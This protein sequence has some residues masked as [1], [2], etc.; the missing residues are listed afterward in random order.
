MFVFAAFVAGHGRARSSGAACARGGR[1][2]ASRC[3]VALV[4]ARAP[5]PAPLRRLH[6]APRRRACC[7]SASP[8]RRPSS[9]PATCGCAP[10]PDRAR[11]RLRHHLR[12][13]TSARRRGAERPA[14]ADRPRRAAARRARTASAS[15]RCAPTRSYFPSA[16]ADARPRG[17]L[18]RGRGDERGRRCA[19]GCARDIWTAVSPDLD[20]LHARIKRGRQASSPAPAEAAAEQRT[21]RS[22]AQALTGLA[23]L[24]RDDPPPATFRLIV[25]PLVTWIWLGAL[26]VFGGG[27]DRDLA[28]ARRSRAARH[29]RLRGARRARARPRLS[30][31]GWTCSE[32]LLVLVVLAPWSAW[33]SARRCAAGARRGR[34]E[35]E[36]AERAELEAAQGGQVPR[37]PRRR[38][39]LPDGK[40]SEAD[41]RAID[42]ALRAEAIEILRELDELDDSNS[43][44]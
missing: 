30:S 22:S 31:R 13:P 11:R 23:E 26:I 21:T 32:S 7:S 25:S 18:L 19:P 12:K 37:D 15:R 5:Q 43:P 1:W 27:A 24:L 40:L 20:A 41:W 4:V 3:R 16:D 44:T 9:T 2:P 6:R 8:P 10:G 35:R 33:S 28:G 38:A 34:T 29:R 42:R 39:R 36:A 17:A 14:R